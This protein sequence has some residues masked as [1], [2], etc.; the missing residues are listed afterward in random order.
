MSPKQFFIVLI[1]LLVLAAPAAA[2]TAASNTSQ[3]GGFMAALQTELAAAI[4]RLRAVIGARDSAFLTDRI[5]IRKKSDTLFQVIP[6]RGETVDEALA[7]YSADPTVA[8]AEPDYIVRALAA[9]NDPYWS[10]QWNLA[11][12]TSG[13]DAEDAWNLA[14]GAGVTVAVIDS[15]IAYENNPPFAAAPDL[16]DT[17]FVPGYDFVNGDDHPDDDNGHG[18]E[19]ASVIAAGNGA[20]MAGIA[21][22]ARLMPLKV[23]DADGNGSYSNLALA[24][25]FAADHGARVINLSL[26]GTAPARYLEEALAYAANKGAVIVAAAGNAGAG[27]LSYPAAYTPYVIAVGATRYDTTKTD[28]SNYGRGLDVVAPGG[29]LSVDQNGDGYADGVLGETWNGTYDNFGYYFYQ[30]TSMAAAHVSGIAA[31]VLSRGL[32]TTTADVRRAIET[33]ATDLGAAGYDTTYGYGL[34]NAYG[35]VEYQP[36]H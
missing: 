9:P 32:A 21:R 30:G 16:A 24:I 36:Q 29:D 35:A 27:A 8:Y 11:N 10:F 6:L 26:G 1:G 33:T 13:I 4:D 15:G 23:L 20:G 31:L 25:R 14:T 18:T 34:V 12:T 2:Q 5:V 3:G 22:N 19:V 17:T 28:Y 7:R